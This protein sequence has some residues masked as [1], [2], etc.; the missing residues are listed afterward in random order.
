M[1]FRSSPY[2]DFNTGKVRTPP[3]ILIQSLGPRSKQSAEQMLMIFECRVDVWQLGPAVEM[4]KL[5][6][7]ASEQTSVWAHAGYTL[8]SAMFSYFEMI[9][10]IVNPESNGWRTSKQDFN[11]GF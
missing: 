2:I 10:K 8:I 7:S 4:L 1:P 11:Y 5:L 3:M 9:G 6:D